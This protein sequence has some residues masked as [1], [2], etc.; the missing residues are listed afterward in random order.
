V[1]LS[2]Y[3]GGKLKKSPKT[4]YLVSLVC[5]VYLVKKQLTYEQVELLNQLQKRQKKPKKPK[6]PEKPFAYSLGTTQ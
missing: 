3:Q 4:V 6:K 2:K 1:S 5:R